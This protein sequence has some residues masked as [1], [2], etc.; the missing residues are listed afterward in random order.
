MDEE[1]TSRAQ[2]AAAEFWAAL[3]DDDDASTE[4]SLAPP[5]QAEVGAGVGIARRV[6]DLLGIGPRECSNIAVL[7]DVPLKGFVDIG[8]YADV[9]RIEY[10]VADLIDDVGDERLVTGPGAEAMTWTLD[11]MQADDHWTVD[12]AE[13]R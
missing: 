7:Q 12:W 9:H 6:R 11:V 1:P 10:M 3:A 13:R 4:G 2:E 5:A 8:G